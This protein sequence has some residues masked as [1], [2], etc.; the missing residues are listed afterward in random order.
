[1]KKILLTGPNGS[2]KTTYIK[3]KMFSTQIAEKDFDIFT[4][5]NKDGD[6]TIGI[7]MNSIWM[8][9]VFKN[10]QIPYVD[11]SRSLV[12]IKEAFIN[13]INKVKEQQ[14]HEA[15]QIES[16]KKEAD[17]YIK[18]GNRTNYDSL[19]RSARTYEE[20]K[21]R[22]PESMVVNI[23]SIWNMD[24]LVTNVLIKKYI[25]E[26]ADTP[27]QKLTFPEIGDQEYLD[28]LLLSIEWIKNNMD[29]NFEK[30]LTILQVN[31]VVEL[32]IKRLKKSVE[33][34]VGD[35]E[36][37]MD[38]WNN[39]MFEESFLTKMNESFKQLRLNIKIS[40]SKEIGTNEIVFLIN[41]TKKTIEQLSTGQKTL[42]LITLVTLIN[43][44]KN[45]STIIFE[46]F[47]AFL[48]PEQIMEVINQ[49]E[50]ISFLQSVVLTSHNP[51]TISRLNDSVE[52][53]QMK[54]NEI[55][56]KESSKKETL[57]SLL[58]FTPNLIVYSFDVRNIFVESNNDKLFY[59]LI[60]EK[61]IHE[62]K[63]KNNIRLLFFPITVAAGA[64]GKDKIYDL[65]KSIKLPNTM[66]IVDNDNGASKETEE[67]FV[68]GKLLELEN[69]IFYALFGIEKQEKVSL[70]EL[71]ENVMKSF[72]VELNNLPHIINWMKDKE[73]ISL[74]IHKDL[75]V[76]FDRLE[77]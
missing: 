46:E 24:N 57:S 56:I 37:V 19:M 67:I 7:Y 41:N 70:E 3:T 22:I 23:D 69:Y 10:I 71:R 74:N 21:V 32:F 49:I 42:L 64:N 55:G 40:I 39:P 5:K 33:N 47:D 26:I 48:N 77:S 1:M 6:D 17:E 59:E 63:S 34:A 9:S 27:I 50:K 73:G 25:E 13:Y 29:F 52:Y 44:D 54:P 38:K 12:T 45:I 51:I 8:Q 31:F 68:A 75:V 76:L 2:G 28:R 60:Y 20:N 11:A 18:R 53:I 35:T 30:P 4:H 61:F 16:W 43:A 72:N 66:A 36:L 65:F 62:G 15:S 14:K 58:K